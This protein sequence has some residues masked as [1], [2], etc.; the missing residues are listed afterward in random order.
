MDIVRLTMFSECG[1]STQKWQ[2]IQKK[3]QHQSSEFT[4]MSPRFQKKCFLFFQETGKQFGETRKHFQETGK[5]FQETRKQFR[6]LGNIFGKQGNIFG[7]QKTFSGNRK[8]IRIHNTFYH[9]AHHKFSLQCSWTKVNNMLYEI[10]KI[11]IQFWMGNYNDT[12]TRK[13]FW[14]A[15]VM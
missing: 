10:C 2:E 5:Q 9:K 12:C 3:G 4:K 14:K 8:T 6:K 15:H 7:N 13:T 11:D 1:I